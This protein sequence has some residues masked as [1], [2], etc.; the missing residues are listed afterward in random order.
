VLLT[1]ALFGQ[2]WSHLLGALDFLVIAAVLYWVARP[3]RR[4]AP[5]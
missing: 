1:A 2:G 5:G 3:P 4:R